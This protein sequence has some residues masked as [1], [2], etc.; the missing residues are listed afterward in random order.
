MEFFIV[1]LATCVGIAVLMISSA[2]SYKLIAS[3]RNQRPNPS[4]STSPTN[5]RSPTMIIDRANQLQD[6][7]FAVPMR[8]P[9]STRSPEDQAEQLR[10]FGST[11]TRRG[12]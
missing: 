1:F 5:V 8:S 7:R 10:R 11:P 9:V 12:R 3:A 4:Q 2:L 6:M